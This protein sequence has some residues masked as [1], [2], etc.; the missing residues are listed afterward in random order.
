MKII[1]GIL[2]VFFFGILGLVSFLYLTQY[3]PR[4]RVVLYTA[5]GDTIP[6][7]KEKTFSAMI[8]NI[9]YAGLDSRMDFFYDGG[10]RVRPSAADSKANLEE[11]KKTLVELGDTVDFLLLQE[12]DER[13]KRSYRLSQVSE[14]EKCF[15]QKNSQFALN[16]KVR[17]V[18]LPI[19]DPMGYVKSGLLTL[20]NAQPSQ[21][22][23]YAFP[24]EFGFPTNLAMLK[25][26]FMVNQYPL[27]N[28]KKLLV[29]NTHN[30]AY[31][32]GTL[33][34]EEMQFFKQYLL[35]E[36]AKG[37]YLLVGGDWNQCPPNFLPQYA[38]EPF[39]TIQRIDIADTYLTNWQWAYD[40]TVPTNRRVRTPYEKGKTK[41]TVIDFYLLS[42]NLEL[43]SVKGHHKGFRYSDHNPV[44][45]RFKIR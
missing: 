8:W 35:R 5:E 32:D 42:P 19:T 12:V 24:S 31:D 30:S 43:L 41:T 28:G 11:I 16:Y 38:D 9:G 21:S 33:R 14:I 39:D 26:C 37:N 27:S 18:P 1:I 40:A 45:L 7:D 3:Q 4:E 10:V 17:F 34:N 29:I 25:R 22:E 6:L 15:V 20:S 23:R 36:Y 2:I 44:S 13:A